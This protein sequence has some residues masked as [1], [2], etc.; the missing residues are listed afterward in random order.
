[1]KDLSN[2]IINN[3]KKTINNDKKLLIKMNYLKI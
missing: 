2:N 1:M 3:D